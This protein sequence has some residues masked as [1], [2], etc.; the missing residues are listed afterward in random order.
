MA[1]S[2]AFQT[3]NLIDGAFMNIA[4]LYHAN[5]QDG[6]GAAYAVYCAFP[7]F[8]IKFIAVN[9]QEAVP[10]LPQEVTLIFIVDFSYS[11]KELDALALQHPNAEICVI[12]HHASTEYLRN[13]VHPQVTVIFDMRESGATLTWKTLLRNAPPKILAHIKDRD[14]FQFTMEGTNEIWAALASYPKT[15]IEFFSVLH[16]KEENLYEQG[17]HIWR[18]HCQVVHDLAQSAIPCR[19][20]LL[21]G[22]I[23]NCPPQFASD[24]GNYLYTKYPSKFIALVHVNFP[25]NAKVGLR[26]HKEYG[27]NV[28][29]IAERFGGG[30]HANA[31]GFSAPYQQVLNVFLAPQNAVNHAIIETRSDISI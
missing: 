26:S 7:T 18:Y 27:I 1:Q 2:V 25:N 14:L 11:P 28:C 10:Q 23:V 31:A 16:H 17:K 21:P 9:Y 20:G 30:G 8:P 24:V 4:C 13:Y 15:P 3:R 19:L 6:L 22:M 12:D 29:R 5:C